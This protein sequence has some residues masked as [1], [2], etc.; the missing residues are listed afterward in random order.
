MLGRERSESGLKYGQKIVV[1]VLDTSLGK[2]AYGMPIKLQGL[3]INGEWELLAEGITDE[4][5]CIEDLISKDAVVKSGRYRL[6]YETAV[7]FQRLGT[8]SLFPRVLLEVNLGDEKKY[9][10]PLL[11]SPFAYTIY[12][13]S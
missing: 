12:R 6:V 13:G 7:Y 2:P 8:S 11:I 10:L 1:F 4:D 5:G 3:D 9:V